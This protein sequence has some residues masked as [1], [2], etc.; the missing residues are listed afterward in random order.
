MTTS[1]PVSFIRKEEAGRN[2]AHLP[3]VESLSSWGRVGMIL[4]S[5]QEGGKEDV[6]LLAGVCFLG[7]SEAVFCINSK[8][9][10]EKL[11]VLFCVLL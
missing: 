9:V 8:T 6:E 2:V 1:L 10:T 3:N 11:P 7:G 4:E 5:L